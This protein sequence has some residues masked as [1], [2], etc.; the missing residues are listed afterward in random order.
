M[1]C[2]F[3]KFCIFEERFDFTMLSRVRL[4][5]P[6]D[7]AWRELPEESTQL[8]AK[9]IDVKAAYKQFPIFPDHRK[10]SIL[11]LKRPTDGVAMGFVSK[12]LPF[13]SVASVLHFNRIARLLH[14]MG[15]ELDIPWTNYYDD[16]PVDFKILSE[17]T[18]AAARALTSML[19]FECSLDK[20]L[21][22]DRSA[23]MLGVVLDLSEFTKGV[24][25]VCN[26]FSRMSELKE[27][28]T[29]I[30]ESGRVPT[31]SLASFFGR[32]L[33]VESQFM[34][35]AGKLALAEFRSMEKANK[36]VVT[37]SEVQSEAMRNLL[38]R[39]D[40]G[41]PRSL[42][43]ERT[44]L[45]CVVFTDGACEHG[46]DDRI[47]CTVGGVIFDPAGEG[48]VEAFGSHVPDSVMESW[49]NASKVHPV[50]QTEMYAECVAR[51]LWHPRIDGR[52]CLFFID[53]KVTLML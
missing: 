19:G 27:V 51:H 53:N 45:P 9:T 20:E 43:M 17:H 5:G 33:F 25:K 29:G 22:F 46:S 7:R 1:A 52:R 15:L 30:I 4:A 28:L 21:P 14:R 26:K 41:V 6:V 3:V 50:A 11:V 35:K 12:T 48:M 18:G 31:K 10:F 13:G 37:L 42:E 32:A 8:V 40:K 39:Y 16:F 36:S 24:V 49:K 44:Q 34:G 38:E 23:E 2:C 47:I